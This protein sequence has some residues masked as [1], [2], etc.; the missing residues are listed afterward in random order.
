MKFAEERL[1]CVRRLTRLAAAL[2]AIAVCASDVRAYD[3]RSSP[4]A[5][6][7]VA[8]TTRE[9]NKCPPDGSLISLLTR[10]AF[11][12]GREPE[13]REYG[14]YLNELAA[15]S[16]SSYRDP[17]IVDK[18]IAAS[19][20][21]SKKMQEKGHAIGLRDLII[22]REATLV[23]VLRSR[24][25]ATPIYNSQLDL[26]LAVTREMKRLMCR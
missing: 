17:E 26:Q 21:F 19:I 9:T 11:D 23:S 22:H 18:S 20:N 4:R 3:E 15:V 6:S 16:I 1:R 8:D 2:L 10:Q 25:P 14:M 5:P 7:P 24:N 12:E 13:G